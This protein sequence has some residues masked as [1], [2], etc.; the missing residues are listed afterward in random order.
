[1]YQVFKYTLYHFFCY[2]SAKKLT[3]V[4]Y[5]FNE[6][7]LKVTVPFSSEEQWVRSAYLRLSVSTVSICYT[8]WVFFAVNDV[9]CFSGT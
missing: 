9:A 3:K 8:G 4:F 6:L 1:M 5:S 2:A 7:D